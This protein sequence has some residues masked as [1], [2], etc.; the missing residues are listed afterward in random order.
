MRRAATSLRHL[1]RTMAPP[2]VP[3]R[4]LASLATTL[5]QR[6]PRELLGT[7]KLGDLALPIYETEDPARLPLSDRLLD[8]SDPYNAENMHWILQVRCIGTSAP[9]MLTGP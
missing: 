1:I 7:L 8:T 9:S 5:E 6:P 4:R 2:S 3:Q